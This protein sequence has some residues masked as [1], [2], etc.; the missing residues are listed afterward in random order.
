MIQTKI[1]SNQEYFFCQMPESELR[2]K[3]LFTLMCATSG[4]LA[5]LTTEETRSRRSQPMLPISYL[6]P[7]S[8]LM[9]FIEKN[10]PLIGRFGILEPGAL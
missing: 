1:L 6:P 2:I 4:G 5:K 8:F 3:R 7:G 10:S 9:A